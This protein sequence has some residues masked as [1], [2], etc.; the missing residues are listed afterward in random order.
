LRQSVLDLATEPSA[1][2][3][4]ASASPQPA[5]QAYH[6]RDILYR[7]V[8]FVFMA[9]GCTA[10]LSPAVGQQAWQRNLLFIAERYHP[11]IEQIRRHQRGLAIIQ[12]GEGQLGVGIQ[13]SLLI[14]P[15]TP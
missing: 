10:I 4:T 11:V 12:L 7:Q 8:E 2:A 14:D 6:V 5:A 3:T 1:W 13:K 15:A 9:L